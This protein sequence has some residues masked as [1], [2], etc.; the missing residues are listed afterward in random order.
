MPDGGLFS[1]LEQKRTEA[2]DFEAA[3]FTNLTQDH[4]DYHLNMENYFLAKAKL[5]SS[6]SE[7]AWAIVNTDSSYA[8]RLKD[9]TRGRFLGYGIGRAGLPA[10]QTAVRAQDLRLWIDGSEFDLEYEGCKTRLKTKLIG[11]HNIY[12]ILASAAFAFSQNVKPGGYSDG[13]NKVLRG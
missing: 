10:C 1:P 8:L 2:I 9:L 7:T 11:R 12:N 13:L 6:L 4:L 5:F 3:I